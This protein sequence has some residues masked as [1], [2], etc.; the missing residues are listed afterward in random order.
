M[1]QELF[2]DEL[3]QEIKADKTYSQIFIKMSNS[4]ILLGEVK[5]IVEGLGVHIIEAK[6]LS[7]NWTLLKLD[8]KDMREVA[9]KLTEQGFL[10]KGINALP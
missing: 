4:P 6:R 5:K 8:A 10:I 2:L 3:N 9:L 7:P 1:I